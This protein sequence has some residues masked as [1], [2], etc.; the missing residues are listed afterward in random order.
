MPIYEY[1]CRECGVRFERR[2]SFD[3]QPVSLCPECGGDVHRLLQPAG[4]IF[5]GKGFYVTD[6]RGKNSSL[7]P[8]G[9]KDGAKS[10]SSEVSAKSESSTKSTDD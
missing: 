6:S 5:K 10:E 1:E 2:Q 3:D 4:I 9:K 8:G 7:T